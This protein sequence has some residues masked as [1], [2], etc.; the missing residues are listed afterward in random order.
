MRALIISVDLGNPD[1]EAHAQE[2]AMLAQGAGA[3]IVDTVTARRDRP[4][5]KYFIGS[6]KVRGG[7][8]AG[9]RARCRRRPVRPALVAGP[10]T[11]P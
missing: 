4:D 11:Q 2:F 5:A 10:A 7:R 9:Q 8:P 3:D 6:G 1:F